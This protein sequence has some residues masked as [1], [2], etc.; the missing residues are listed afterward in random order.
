MY[1]WEAHSLLS[2]LAVFFESPALLGLFVG[3]LQ[4]GDTMDEVGG[5]TRALDDH[6]PNVPDYSEVFMLRSSVG[7]GER[8]DLPHRWHGRPARVFL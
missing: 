5:G 8:T 4:F 6:G 3:T 2:S 7:L 1:G